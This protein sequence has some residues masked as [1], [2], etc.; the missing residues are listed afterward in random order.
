MDPNTS[1]AGALTPAD[2]RYITE[3]FVPLR[4]VAA[5]RPETPEALQALIDSGHLPR[6]TYTLADGTG[7]FPRDVLALL[8]AAGSP[9]AVRAH[10]DGRLSRMAAR[11]GQAL[12]QERLDAEWRGYLKGHYGACLR[13]VTPEHI[14]C[15]E[16]LVLR[17]TEA[18][19]APA[20]E[21][22]AWCARLL[23]DVEALDALEREFAPWDR[24]RF[25]GPVSRDRLITA[26]RERYPHLF[27]RTDTSSGARLAC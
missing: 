27:A 2:V 4:T 8:D 1:G 11:F 21:E 17:L 20:P 13:V 19:A 12:A 10:F 6:P 16:R 14:F 25:G 7:M 23:T 3:H 18:L 24:L 5:G 26:P 9:D 22:E 15:K